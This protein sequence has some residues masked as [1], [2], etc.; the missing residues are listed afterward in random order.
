MAKSPNPSAGMLFLVLRRN[1][2]TASLS[3]PLLFV[4]QQQKFDTFYYHDMENAGKKGPLVAVH[5]EA[6]P[7]FPLIA[8]DELTPSVTRFRFGLPSEKHRLGWVITSSS[9]QSSDASNE[10][11]AGLGSGLCR[12]FENLRVAHTMRAGLLG[13]QGS[14]CGLHL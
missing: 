10:S 7:S 12:G 8:K 6:Q 13:L 14:V 2:V 11:H 5:P 1:S 9:L 4:M 3:S